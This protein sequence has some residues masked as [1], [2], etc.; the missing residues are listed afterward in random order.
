MLANVLAVLLGSGSLIFYLAAFFY[1]EVH[2]RSDFLWSGLGLFYAVVLWFCAGQM[3]GAVLLG[4]MTAVSLLLGLGWQTLTVRREKTPVYQQT[5]AV[6]T[7]ERVG[8]WAKSKLNQLRIA[9]AATVPAQLEKRQLGDRLDPRRRPLYEYEFVEDGV[10]D[11]QTLADPAASEVIAHPLPAIEPTAEPTD[12]APPSADAEIL[13]VEE[14]EPD[15]SKQNDDPQNL[16]QPQVAV[17]DIHFDQPTVKTELDDS[18]N[19]IGLTETNIPIDAEDWDLELSEDGVG[20]GRE[21]EFEAIADA[22]RSQ[23]QPARSRENLE[24]P[25]LLATPLILIG[26]VR[27]VLGSFTRAKSAKPVIDIP[28]RESDSASLGQANYPSAPEQAEGDSFLDD[29]ADAVDTPLDFM[30]VQDPP[31]DD[32]EESNWD[33]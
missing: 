11:G 3:S 33:D 21:P 25:S 24:R 26:W 5:P 29:T 32:W 31:S 2:R 20:R 14:P 6:L 7:P 8:N 9:P 10:T 16:S 18:S 28:R 19:D 17:T 15:P 22:G 1:P 23:A 30:S 4:Q 12:A 27:D 13:L